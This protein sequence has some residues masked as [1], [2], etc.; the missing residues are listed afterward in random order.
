MPLIAKKD[1]KQATTSVSNLRL[2]PRVGI[3]DDKMS[4]PLEA[5]MN[6]FFNHL[7]NEKSNYI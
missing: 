5:N 6:V 1:T 2:K 7:M 4:F 3:W